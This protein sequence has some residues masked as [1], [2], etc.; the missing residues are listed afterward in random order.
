MQSD[1]VIQKMYFMLDY[2]IL[3]GKI[4]TRKKE[5]EMYEKFNNTQKA[6]TWEQVKGSKTDLYDLKIMS[7]DTTEFYYSLS[8]A[9]LNTILKSEQIKNNRKYGRT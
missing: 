4:K 5:N 3:Y 1:K 9:E 6:L 7:L 8:K 2:I